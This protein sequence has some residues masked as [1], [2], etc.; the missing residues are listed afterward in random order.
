MKSGLALN[1]KS[2]YLALYRD[3][4]GR[5][6]VEEEKNRGRKEGRKWV[7]GLINR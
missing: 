7:G 2:L 4:Q 6:N 1:P 3:F 5:R